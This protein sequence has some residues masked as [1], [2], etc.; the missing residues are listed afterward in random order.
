MKKRV[1]NF[2]RWAFSTNEKLAK[3]YRKWLKFEYFLG[4]IY[5]GNAIISGLSEEYS[6]M[7]AYLIV[8]M[9]VFILHLKNIRLLR[10]DNTINSYKELT[11][12]MLETMEK[13]QIQLT[14]IHYN[15]KEFKIS[16]N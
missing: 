14:K 8:C 13:Q 9:F 12:K 11:D 5:L 2:W 4:I 10:R 16:K 15:P 6:K 1:I 7:M 3:F